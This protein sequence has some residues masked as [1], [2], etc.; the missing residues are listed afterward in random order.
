VLVALC[1]GTE[2]GETG[3]RTK[4]R[5]RERQ[6]EIENYRGREGEGGE[7]IAVVMKLSLERKVLKRSPALPPAAPLPPLELREVNL[8]AIW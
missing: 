4:E 5:R 3:G 6:K 8:V 1:K 2:E 7:R